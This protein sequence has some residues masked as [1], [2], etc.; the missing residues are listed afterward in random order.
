MSTR[1]F[2]Y[3]LSEGMRV[4][5]RPTYLREQSAPYAAQHVF[6]YHVRIE[7]VGEQS[8]QLLTRRWLIHDDAG[9]GHARRRG[10][11]RRRAAVIAPGACT[12]TAASAS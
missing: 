6:A 3:R 11:R 4:T 12:S 7:N 9:G 1:T 10:G 2:F 5:V 8:A